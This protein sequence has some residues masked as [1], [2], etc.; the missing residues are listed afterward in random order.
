[1][2]RIRPKQA[3]EVSSIHREIT[4]LKYVSSL[5]FSSPSHFAGYLVYISCRK[6]QHT[7]VVKLIG[8]CE[9]DKSYYI[10]MEWIEGMPK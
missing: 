5:L 6:S 2:K 1:M 9:N 10:V 3:S 4:L 8:H 7:N